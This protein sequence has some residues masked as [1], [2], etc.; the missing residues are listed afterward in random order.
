MMGINTHVYMVYGI[1]IDWDNDFYEAYEEIEE[2]L[3]DEFGY[4][5]PH[6]ADRQVQAIMDAMCGGYMILGH[7]LYD[8]GD[9][10]YCEDMNSYQEIGI[11]GSHLLVWLDYK[12]Q[13]SRLYP[14]HVHLIENKDPKL[15][16]LIHY[17]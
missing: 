7:V 5:K 14:A 8:S 15:I 1:R 4:N 16:N 10:R 12:A 3:L 2:A 17:S 9:F 11:E 13:F 6:P